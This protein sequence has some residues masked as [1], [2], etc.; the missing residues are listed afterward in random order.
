MD[1]RRI[2]MCERCIHYD[3]CK[4]KDSFVKFAVKVPAAI[5]PVVS[6]AVT[7]QAFK[8]ERYYKVVRSMGA[9]V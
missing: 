3:V 2:T 1:D 9:E 4:Y 7:C 5:E 8:D 6:V